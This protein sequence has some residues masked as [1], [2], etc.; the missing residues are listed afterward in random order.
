MGPTSALCMCRSAR[1]GNMGNMPHP[2]ATT[3]SRGDAVG[4]LGPRLAIAVLVAVP[5]AVAVGLL[6]L[7]VETSW[8]PMRGLDRSIADALHA[9]AL[10]HPAWVHAMAE[11]SNVGSPT[12]MRVATGLLAVARCGFATPDGSHCGSQRP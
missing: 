6:V 1:G 7:A 10:G 3:P 9:Q 5:A 4:R 2:R 12:V 11:V 8:A